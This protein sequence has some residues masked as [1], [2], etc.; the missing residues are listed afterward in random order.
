MT[1]ANPQRDGNSIN[2]AIMKATTCTSCGGIHL[3]LV[4]YNLLGEQ[5]DS[6]RAYPLPEDEAI[7]VVILIVI[8]FYE[9]QLET[10]PTDEQRTE[11]ASR[12]RE[13]FRGMQAKAGTAAWEIV[14]KYPALKKLVEDI[15]TG[16]S[17]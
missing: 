9:S 16:I 15:S 5:Q 6:Q 11:L 17:S 12:L 4:P 8:R 14:A 7:E 13:G 2:T 10:P 1:C 3:D